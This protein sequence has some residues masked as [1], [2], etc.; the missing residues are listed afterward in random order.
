[1]TLECKSAAALDKLIDD[2]LA[3]RVVLMPTGSQPP[4]TEQDV[5]FEIKLTF[6]NGSPG[7]VGQGRVIQILEGCFGPGDAGRGAVIEVSHAEKLAEA[8]RAAKGG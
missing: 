4:A 2:Q 1:M 6:V 3:R 8:L 5:E 7:A